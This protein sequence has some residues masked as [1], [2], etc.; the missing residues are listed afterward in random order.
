MRSILITGVIFI[1]FPVSV[2]AQAR[3]VNRITPEME[4]QIERSKEDMEKARDIHL[5]DLKKSNPELYKARLNAIDN[6]EEMNKIVVS[7]REGKISGAKA[8]K[9]LYPLVEDSL[10]GYLDSLDERIEKEQKKVDSLKEVKRDPDILIKKRI[11]QI[12]GK[13]APSADDFLL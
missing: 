7:Y 11:D 9:E 2:F 5:N 4:K 13:A 12:L 3:Q 8:E 6:Q 10:K 1:F